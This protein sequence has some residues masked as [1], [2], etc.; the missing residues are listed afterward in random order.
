MP[1]D[2]TL[3]FSKAQSLDGSPVKAEVKLNFDQA[4]HISPQE[5]SSHKSSTLARQNPQGEISADTPTAI[6]LAV[7]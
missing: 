5:M 6:K 2:V 4:Q 1:T 3:D 7:K